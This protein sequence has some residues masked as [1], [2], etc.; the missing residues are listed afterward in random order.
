MSLLNEKKQ[1]RIVFDK[2]LVKDMLN[3]HLDSYFPWYYASKTTDTEKD[4]YQFVHTFYKFDKPTSNHFPFIKKFIDS[5]VKYKK[6]VYLK[7][8][9][10]TRKNISKLA[11]HQDAPDDRYVSLLYYVNESDG[12]TVFKIKDKTIKTKP[13]KGTGLLFK[14]N[15]NHSATNPKK[16]DSRIVLS[17]IMEV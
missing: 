2:T 3:L 13:I 5:K 14:S 1:T 12:E 17:C 10:T 7:S 4:N 16:Y 8:N 6:I 15:I 11:F 9:F